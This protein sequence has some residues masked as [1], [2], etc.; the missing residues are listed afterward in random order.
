MKRQEFAVALRD[1]RVY[2][3]EVEHVEGKASVVWFR[4]YG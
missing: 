4:T 1:G 3:I 2:R